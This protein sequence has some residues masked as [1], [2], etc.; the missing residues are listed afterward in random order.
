MILFYF[1]L[2]SLLCFD[3]FVRIL[4]LGHEVEWSGAEQSRTERTGQGRA[5]KFGE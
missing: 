3:L 1:L 5:E 4:L 2:L